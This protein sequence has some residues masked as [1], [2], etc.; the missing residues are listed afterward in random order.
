MA[1]RSAVLLA[2]AHWLN[3]LHTWQFVYYLPHDQYFEVGEE[4]FENP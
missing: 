4:T 1:Q 3:V 2:A